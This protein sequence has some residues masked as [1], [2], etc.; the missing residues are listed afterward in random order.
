MNGGKKILIVEDDELIIKI[1]EFI[2]N[3]E[4]YELSVLR[5]G[6]S[7][8]ENLKMILFAYVECFL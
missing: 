5:D 2:L 7:A 1:L 3:K 4:G 8:I 6:L